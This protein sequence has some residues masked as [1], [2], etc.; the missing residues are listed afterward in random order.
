MH[1]L[2]AGIAVTTGLIIGK[3]Y[4]PHRGHA[5]LID[6]A[7]RRVDH[8]VVVV[9]SRADETIPGPLRAEWLRELHPDVEVVHVV[10]EFREPMNQEDTEA[11]DFW[12]DITRQS[13]PSKP[14]VL[15]TSEDYG[16]E[17]A[18]RLGVQH[19]LV[20]RARQQVPISGTQVRAN[21]F[22]HWDFIAPCVRAYFVATF[23]EGES[24]LTK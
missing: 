17:L 12:T 10:A 9:M 23:L 22:A 24:T 2:R 13:C 18:R 4:P 14:D 20:D 3:F 7:R 1:Q 19:A 21:P 5:Y 15:F 6:F 8:L 11:W 16:D